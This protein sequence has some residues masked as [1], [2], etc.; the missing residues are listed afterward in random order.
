MLIDPACDWRTGELIW[1]GAKRRRRRPE[2][3]FDG[4]L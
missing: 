4:L 1:S 3:F 2:A